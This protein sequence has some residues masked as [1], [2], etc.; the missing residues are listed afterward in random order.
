M[1]C[2]QVL[3]TAGCWTAPRTLCPAS[4]LPPAPLSR[5]EPCGHMAA[6]LRCRP[7]RQAYAAAA[8]ADRQ[9]L[10]RTACRAPALLQQRLA[11][12]Q[13]QAQLP[14]APAEPL[15][16]ARRL[17]ARFPAGRRARSATTSLCASTWRPTAPSSSRSGACAVPRCTSHLSNQAAVTAAF[18]LPELTCWQRIHGTSCW[19]HVLACQQNINERFHWADALVPRDCEFKRAP[20]PKPGCRVSQTIGGRGRTGSPRTAA[21][22]L[23]RW[24]LR[25]A[26]RASSLW[27]PRGVQPSVTSLRAVPSFRGCS[28]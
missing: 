2:E 18:R 7:Q 25:T 4:S 26:K 14:A 17:H 3:S 12:V 9:G 6:G 19:P 10:R 23:M 21:W 8:L 20:E 5:R 28:E 22:A 27:T 24:K 11:A 13:R 1:I 15:L 16:C